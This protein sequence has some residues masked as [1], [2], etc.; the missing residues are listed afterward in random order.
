MNRVTGGAAPSSAKVPPLPAWRQRSYYRSRI[1]MTGR[2]YGCWTVIRFAVEEH[3]PGRQPRWLCRC[4]CGTERTVA[5]QMLRNGRSRSCGCRCWQRRRQRMRASHLMR[6]ALG[7]GKLVR[8][9]TCQR[10]GR[11]GRIEGHHFRGYE[12]EH[13]LSIEWVCRSCHVRMPHPECVDCEGRAA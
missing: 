11:R 2:R 13:A 4:A 3:V 9:D 1:D 7:N 10:C 8:P 6:R 5:G 12:D